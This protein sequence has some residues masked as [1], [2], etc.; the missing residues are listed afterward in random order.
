MF[1]FRLRGGNCPVRYHMTCG[2]INN[3]G[4]F[5]VVVVVLFIY[6]L[7]VLLAC[8][9]F[10]GGDVACDDELSC[11]CRPAIWTI[12]FRCRRTWLWS[13]GNLERKWKCFC[14]INYF[15]FH[16]SLPL[17]FFVLFLLFRSEVQWRNGSVRVD[18]PGFASCLEH[19]VLSLHVAPVYNT[20]WL[21]ERKMLVPLPTFFLF[22][23]FF[24]LL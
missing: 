12:S 6:F 1:W 22:F 15:S 17:V 11:C 3:S 14:K 4:E 23:S 24:L 10:L 13:R 20:C 7:A 18:C 2:W 8:R 5:L 9:S 16:S 21:A 19:D